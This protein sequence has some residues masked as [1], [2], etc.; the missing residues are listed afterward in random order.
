MAP[1]ANPRQNGITVNGFATRK[2]AATSARLTLYLYSVAT[3][4]RPGAPLTPPAP[5]DAAQLAPLIDALVAMGVSRDN[6]TIPTAFGPQ[7]RSATVIATVANPTAAM[8]QNGIST[9]G[10]ALASMPNI[11]LG[12]AQVTLESNRCGDATDA[13]RSAAIANARAKASSTAKDLGV[14]LGPVQSVLANDQSSQTGSC[15]WQYY[16]GQGNMPQ[17]TSPDDWVS[18]QVSSA[19]TITYAIK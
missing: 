15:T 6:I 11:S 7:D 3:P 9:V 14:H 16:M 12:N 13:S 2:T 18:V 17:I 5:L 1:A 10:H 4:Q 8:I 19:V